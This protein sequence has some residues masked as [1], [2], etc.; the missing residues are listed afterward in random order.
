MVDRIRRGSLDARDRK[1]LTDV[2]RDVAADDSSGEGPPKL[3]INLAGTELLQQLGLS[4]SA[5]DQLRVRRPFWHLDEIAELGLS[6][7]LQAR[8]RRLFTVA[9]LVYRDKTSSRRVILSADPEETVVASEPEAEALAGRSRGA[10]PT[11]VPGRH[12]RRIRGTD[13]E[14]R[15]AESLAGSRL[16]PA[17]RD[18]RGV[19]RYLDPGFIAVQAVGG[20]ETDEVA[21]LL[22][23][24]GL[25]VEK[26]FA[27]P[28]L[29]IARL[30]ADRHGSAGLTS[31]LAALGASPAVVFAE[32]AWIGFD[33]LEAVGSA[34]G[35]A[36]RRETGGD[37]EADA[38]A[39]LPWNLALVGAE[40]V[41]AIGRGSPAVLLV[42]VDTGVDG[43]HP[44]I[45]PAILPT[46]AGERRNFA[47][48]QDVPTDQSGHGTAVAGF[49]VGNGAAGAFGLA[50]ECRLLPLRVPLSAALESY[51]LRRDALLSLLPRLAAGQ[52]LVVNIS[53]RTAGD[54]ALV[55]TAVES[56]HA[57][58]AVVVCSAGNSGSPPG[59]A[60]FPS[61][62][63][64]TISVA[65]VDQ[66]GLATDY[67][68][69]GPQVDLAAPG[70]SAAVPLI[71]AALGGA[72][73]SNRGT[74]FAAP[75]V[76]AAAALIWSL[77]PHLD[78]AGVRAAL[79]SSA[80]TN[81][82]DLGRGLLDLG[83]FAD[84]LASPVLPPPD[85][86]PPVVP[87]PVVPPPVATP[88]T[89][90]AGAGFQIAGSLLVALGQGCGLK[91]ITARILGARAVVRGWE[92]VAGILGMT[93][94]TLSCLQARMLAGGTAGSPASAV[95]TPPAE[96]DFPIVGSVLVGLAQG[97]GLKAVT[98]RILGG[99]PAV[100]GWEEVSGL[101]GMTSSTL[102]CLQ[103]RLA[104]RTRP[105]PG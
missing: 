46:G 8:L 58:G 80:F 7:D 64:Q 40:R 44:A 6:A 65:A 105:A 47:E 10:A 104:A 4:E 54:V 62:Y 89:P 37:G 14:S 92:E 49:M 25:V 24:L 52:R 67:T 19:S 45:A 93:A 97:C 86:P 33:D 9:P 100:S 22:Q 96:T 69:R 103:A 84:S 12:Y 75:H 63:P 16:F 38:E 13:A 42:S 35:S 94:P 85:V 57:A 23:T 28:G 29:F 2:E 26:R 3:D 21:Q 102:S 34:A 98:A 36:A 27:T 11:A 5:A 59:A 15:D 51:A 55:R 68:D 83:R 61:D 88:V 87:P 82:P 70:G 81:D 101:L 39:A 74:S 66:A 56:L 48:D 95:V 32:P 60:H 71:C 18:G 78:A 73:V 90:S 77:R 17:F 53:W 91:A 79:E 76:A 31:V 20:P 1:V 30:M 41:W 72:T 99:R 50:P 43:G